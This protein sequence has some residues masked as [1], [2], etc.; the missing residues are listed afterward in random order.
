[1]LTGLDV[2]ILCLGTA[3]TGAII[4]WTIWGAWENERREI[5]RFFDDGGEL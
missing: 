4:V 2:L 1:M 3:S 5:R